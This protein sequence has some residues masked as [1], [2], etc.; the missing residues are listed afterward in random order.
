MSLFQ[1]PDKELVL[2]GDIGGTKTHLAL[3]SFQNNNLKS[4]IQK[5]FSS[6]EYS[7]LEPVL[8]EFLA[9][10]EYSIGRA[11]FGI[12]GPV[13]DGKVKTPNL[14]WIVDSVK[15]AETLKLPVGFSAQRSPSHRLW[16]LYS[17]VGR[18]S[19]PQRRCHQAAG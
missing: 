15:I 9:G 8:E 4:E 3:F 16:P 6:Q 14:S 5:T 12:A 19:R 18:V 10:G 17:R 7:G 2:A 1:Q 11:S 13:V